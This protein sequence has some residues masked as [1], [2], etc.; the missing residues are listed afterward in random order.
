MISYYNVHPLK[1]ILLLQKTY[2]KLALPTNK[3]QIIVEHHILDIVQ[4]N[5]EEKN[6]LK[7]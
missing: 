1:C 3:F 6:W 2:C 5:N 4:I 7:S